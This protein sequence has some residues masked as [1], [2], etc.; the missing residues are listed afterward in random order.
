MSAGQR[1]QRRSRS[2]RK[3]DRQ[4]ALEQKARGLSNGEIAS[5][6]Q[7]NISTVRRF[8]DRMQPELGAVEDFKNGRANVLAR[9]QSK[10]LDVQERLIDSLGEERVLTALTPSQKSALLFSTNTVFG[11][12]FDKERLETGK[13]TQNHSVIARMMG[14]AVRTAHADQAQ[15]GEAAV[16]TQE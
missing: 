5:L 2:A 3:L 16:E 1:P 7:V 10:A 14:D 11:T 9:I 15:A 4:T 13:S 6:Q 8:M 12:L